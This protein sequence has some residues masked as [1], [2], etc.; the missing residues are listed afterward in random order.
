[1]RK[2]IGRAVL[3][4]V[5]AALMTSA[6]RGAVEINIQQGDAGVTTSTSGSLN[7]E[8]MYYSDLGYL[9]SSAINP[10]NYYFANPGGI[11]AYFGLSSLVNLGPNPLTT[12]ATSSTGSAFG[13]SSN[14]VYVPHGYVSGS[15]LSASSNFDG[16]TLASIGLTAGTYVYSTA[17]DTIT[18]NISAVPEPGTWAMMLF[19]FAFIG[20][21][22]R[23][24]GGKPRIPSL[25]AS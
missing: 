18:V 7:L 1:M 12:V 4:S 10:Q 20:W 2:A 19:G 11:D 24:K 23:R 13:I 8:G 16:Q 9:S 5:I 25:V 3:G 22:L 17:H 6:A 21:A 14:F 15:Q